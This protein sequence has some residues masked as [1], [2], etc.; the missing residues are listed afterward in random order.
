MLSPDKVSALKLVLSCSMQWQPGYH[1]KDLNT[2]VRPF[3]LRYMTGSIGSFEADSLS[4]VS[5]PRVMYFSTFLFYVRIFELKYKIAAVFFSFW[6]LCCAQNPFTCHLR[7]NV[8]T[9]EVGI[10]AAENCVPLWILWLVGKQQW[11]RQCVLAVTCF[12]RAD[13]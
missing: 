1:T 9:D 5:I 12:S 6:V 2:F 10:K 7:S 3:P 13:L 11:S 8:T 4:E